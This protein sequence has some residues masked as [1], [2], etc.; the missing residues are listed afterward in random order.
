MVA[1]AIAASWE[2]SPGW[3]TERGERGVSRG[4]VDGHP[5]S[6]S[7]ARMRKPALV[8]ITV[9]TL[10]CGAQP[11]ASDHRAADTGK[12]GPATAQAESEMPVSDDE[13]A[14]LSSEF[15]LAGCSGVTRLRDVRSEEYFAQSWRIRGGEQ[16]FRGWSER[17]ERYAIL[18]HLNASQAERDR[19][20]WLCSETGDHVAECASQGTDDTLLI[21]QPRDAEFILLRRIKRVS[22]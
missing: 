8:I 21:Q 10:G 11:E 15:G 17:Q 6:A 9:A 19:L 13:T 22:E 1:A 12:P 4:G 16:C 3:C 18:A 7:L 2:D 5:V 14:K 20:P